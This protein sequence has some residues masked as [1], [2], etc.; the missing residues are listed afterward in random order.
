MRNSEE[1]QVDE[2]R[3]IFQKYGGRKSTDLFWRLAQLMGK[4]I[5]AIFSEGADAE[6]KMKMI[7]DAIS[8]LFSSLSPGEFVKLMEDLMDGSSIIANGKHETIN[9]D[10][11]FRG[12]TG[13]LLKV[14]RKMIE[15][16]Y[17]N[18]L[19]DLAGMFPEFAAKI[20]QGIAAKAKAA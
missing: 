16:Q 10:R 8:G 17:E 1:V 20:Q 5:A 13:H 9:F 2:T 14:A 18:F 7:G 12:R 11:D 6:I 3:Y 19:A 15:F 4:P